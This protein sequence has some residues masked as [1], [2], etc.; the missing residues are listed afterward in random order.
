MNIAQR[1]KML[2]EERNLSQDDLAALAA[3]SQKTI[4]NIENG[5]EPKAQNVVQL[6]NALQ[7]TADF[8]L[9]LSDEPSLVQ[10]NVTHLE[11][12]LIDAIR[13]GDKLKAIAMIMN[14]DE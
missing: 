7:V 9:G 14:G 10:I 2:R 8:L 4:S 13:R 1:L 6:A 3:V 11:R 12:R 5:T